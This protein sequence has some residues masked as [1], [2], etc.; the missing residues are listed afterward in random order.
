[1]SRDTR[2]VRSNGPVKHITVIGSRNFMPRTRRG[3][4]LEEEILMPLFIPLVG[5]T[6]CPGMVR[7]AKVQAASRFAFEQQLRRSAAGPACKSL[8]RG[9]IDF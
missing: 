7:T 6:L 5:E 4:E 1:M 9:A 3:I 2:A 8:V